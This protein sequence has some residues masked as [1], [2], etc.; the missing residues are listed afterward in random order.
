MAVRY[1]GQIFEDRDGEPDMELR[2]VHM[3]T[4]ANTLRALAEFLQ[5]AASRMDQFG[6][7]FNQ[8]AFETESLRFI[9]SRWYVTE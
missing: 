9:V 2:A 5:Q 4:D 1:F 8:E 6:D 3:V 7:R